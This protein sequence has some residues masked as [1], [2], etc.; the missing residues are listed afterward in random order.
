MKPLE[1]KAL[2][3]KALG[4]P[5]RIRIVELLCDCDTLC[6]NAI[7]ERTGARQSMISQHLKILKTAGL[8]SSSREGFH[9]HYRIDRNTL[10]ELHE[11]MK[12]FVEVRAGK[13][14]DPSC[15]QEP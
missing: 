12:V 4:D 14:A 7:A 10:A 2:L 9:I 6:V 1:K 13:C 11:M 5:T 3:F 8:V 15:S